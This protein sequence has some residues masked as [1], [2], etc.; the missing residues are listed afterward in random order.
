MAERALRIDHNTLNRYVVHYAP[1]LEKSFHKKK[2]RAGDRWR[3]GETYLKVRGQWRYYY[4]V[5]DNEGK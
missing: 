4:R 2:K 3:M 5:V 1:K